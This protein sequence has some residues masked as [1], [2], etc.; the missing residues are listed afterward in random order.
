MNLQQFFTI[1]WARK[2][3][4]IIY[5][6][7]TVLTA[8][9]LSLIMPK[10]YISTTSLFL[11]QR[12]VDPITGTSVVPTQLLSGYIATQ[13][14]IISSHSVAKK[15]VSS[16][17]LTEVKDYKDAFTKAVGV[18][19][20]EDW[21][22]EDL[23]K[24]LSVKPSRES[25]IIQV[26]FT[27][28]D[29]QFCMQ[30]ANAFAKQYIQT[31]VD[32]RIQP[33]QQNADWFETQLDSLR[34]SM[35][36]ARSR[37]SAL[38]Q[39]TGIIASDDN[40]TIEEMRLNEL[41]QQLVVSQGNTYELQAKKQ[42]LSQALNDPNASESLAEILSNSFIQTLKSD[43]SRA[44]AKFAELS[45]KVDK[46]HPQ[47]QQA[48][49]EISN[50]KHKING[51]IRTVLNGINSSVIASKQRD[52]IL[53]QALDKQKQQIL[54]VKKHQNDIDVLT[55][56]VANIQKAYDAALLRS[57]QTRMESEA[58]LTNIAVLNPAVL[59]QKHDS[60]KLLLNVLLG[61]FL[62]TLLGIG[63]ALISEMRDRRIRN[64][65]DISNGLGLPVFGVI[66]KAAPIKS[67]RWL[68]GE[69][70]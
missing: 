67:K 27:D 47:Y 11:E 6:S 46:N 49:A 50:I 21:I 1:L 28:S 14:D 30:L 37:L 38:Q 64:P 2:W 26:S 24:K 39:S 65:I 23:L 33:A 53:S 32:L 10:Q 17:K 29:P 13:S 43:L 63:A 54:E 70:S 18:G 69:A 48:A 8:L 60:P 16:L 31:T 5:L 51:E 62:G 57:V 20:L 45:V 7:I 52:A 61:F 25:S 35:E 58:S 36:A 15:V 22:A 68:I 4:L 41:A 34:Q 59:P 12:V 9:I 42:Q 40:K 44:E 56:E 66:T 3:L 19:E 55:E